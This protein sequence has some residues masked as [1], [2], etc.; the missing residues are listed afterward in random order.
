MSLADIVQAGWEAVGA[1]DFDTLVADYTEDMV[2]IMPGQADLLTGRQ[3]FR[4]ALN[5]LGDLLPPGFEITSLRQIEGE[6]EV[7]SILEWKSTKIAASQLMVL[8]KF[9][10]SKIVEERWFVDTEQWK[11]AFCFRVE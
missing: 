5:G 1:G 3:A 7:V 10:G 4:E 8:F 9:D 11:S 6:N 2:F